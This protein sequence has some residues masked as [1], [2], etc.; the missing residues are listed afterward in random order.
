MR[1]AVIVEAVRSPVGKGKPGGTL[2]SVHPVQL[3]AHSL[4]SLVD[5]SGIDPGL[6]DDVIGGNVTQVGEQA[7]N[8]TRWAW[9]S[10]GF[11]E[12]VPATTIDRQCG[13]SQQ[14]IH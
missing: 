9:L 10:A 14:A 2:S 11:P 8:T 3:F 5:R 13:S 4:G 1:D 6:V 12:S 7:M